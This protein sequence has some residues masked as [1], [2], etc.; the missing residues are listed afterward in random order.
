MPTTD[1]DH[2][3]LDLDIPVF[4]PIEGVFSD[5]NLSEILYSL[6]GKGEIPS[7]YVY[8]GNGIK[9]WIN[10][11][12]S[13]K[14]ELTTNNYSGIGNSNVGKSY[15]LM[16]ENLDLILGAFSDKNCVNVVDI[17]T[18][19]G[20]PV[21]P[22]LSY[23]QD[24]KKLGKYIAIDIVEEMCDLA[25]K[26]LTNIEPLT[27][28]KTQKYV[29]DFEYGHFANLML[30]ERKDGVVNFFTLI[31]ATLSNLLDRHRALANIRDSMTEG[32]LLWVGIPLY[33]Y[34]NVTQI[35]N[36]YSKKQKD[37][38]DYIKKSNYHTCPLESLGMINWSEFG[39]VLSEEVDAKGLLRYYF[40]VNKPFILE[41][42][43]TGKNKKIVQLKYQNGDEITLNRRKNYYDNDLVTEFRECGFIIKMMNVSKDYSWALILASV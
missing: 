33:V 7:K 19:T 8:F 4:R 11:S 9:N 15:E 12:V 43:K 20:F 27:K 37:P 36:L 32:D 35:I 31:G 30:N 26:N 24:K 34:N 39:K 41:I 13:N 25:I 10:L 14:E 42:P 29:H 5:L 1:H 3:L 2:H 21:Y 23:L 6:E 28:I 16:N 22:I 40:K 38:T 18:G 17:G